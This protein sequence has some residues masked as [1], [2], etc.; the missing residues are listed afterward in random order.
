M[1][2]PWSVLLID[3]TSTILL[4]A[5]LANRNLYN[6]DI[7]CSN[8]DTKSWSLPLIYSLYLTFFN[9]EIQL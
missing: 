3:E 2:I 4:I 5:G 8:T 1:T 9:K 7:L 6:K